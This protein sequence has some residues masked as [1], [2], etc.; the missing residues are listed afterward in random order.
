MSS[1]IKSTETDAARV[2][3]TKDFEIDYTSADIK[4]PAINLFLDLGRLVDKQ[5]KEKMTDKKRKKNSN[6]DFDETPL[7]KHLLMDDSTIGAIPKSM[8][9]KIGAYL[10]NLMCKNLK[11]KMGNS[12]FLLLKPQ[13]I[14]S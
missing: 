2:A 13:L 5:L 4:V 6:D 12:K 9:I 8:Q 3:Q 1:F 11:F 7:E 14:R 10:S